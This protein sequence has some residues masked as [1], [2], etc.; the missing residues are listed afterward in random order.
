MLNF[1]KKRISVKCWYSL[2]F[3]SS[4]PYHSNISQLPIKYQQTPILSVFTLSPA[5]TSIISFIPKS[6]N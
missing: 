5:N 4:L 2:F 6:K 1:N 3:A